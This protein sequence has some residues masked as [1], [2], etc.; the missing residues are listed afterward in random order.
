M[1]LYGKLT[2]G[3]F[4]RQLVISQNP[5]SRCQNF[6]LEE[7]EIRQNKFRISRKHGLELVVLYSVMITNHFNS[8][9]SATSDGRKKSLETTSKNCTIVFRIH[10]VKPSTQIPFPS[11]SLFGRKKGLWMGFV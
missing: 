3:K 2:V 6:V 7:K 9:F 5:G 4:I 1:G 8:Y 11:C 10:F